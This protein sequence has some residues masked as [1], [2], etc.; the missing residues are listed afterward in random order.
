MLPWK[1]HSRGVVS[2]IK[3]PVWVHLGGTGFNSQPCQA[4]DLQKSHQISSSAENSWKLMSSV[5]DCKTADFE[6]QLMSVL[7]AIFKWCA[8]CTIGNTDVKLETVV[9]CKTADI[10]VRCPWGCCFYG[11]KM[12]SVISLARPTTMKGKYGP[13]MPLWW[14]IPLGMR[15]Q[16][17]LI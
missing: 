7:L 13:L 12:V 4:K 15:G 10:G 6:F 8:R 9:S 11:V 5:Q 3:C 1:Q 16:E 17:W 14:Q 2:V